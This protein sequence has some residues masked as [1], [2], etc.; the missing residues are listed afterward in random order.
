MDSTLSKRHRLADGFYALSS[1]MGSQQLQMLTEPATNQ[2]VELMSHPEQEAEMQFLLGQ[3]Y[4]DF[5]APLT[6]GTY[7]DL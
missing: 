2:N 4:A 3:Q 7:R 1:H 6:L 5:I